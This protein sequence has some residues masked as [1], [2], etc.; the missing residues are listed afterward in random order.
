MLRL[1]KKV[2]TKKTK[3]NFM[4]CLI[5]LV[6]VAVIAGGV[7]ILGNLKGGSAGEGSQ[8]ATIRY[9]IELA[10]EEEEVL[11]RFVAAAE[12]QDSCYVGEKERAK[13]IIREVTY[14]EAKLQTT[15]KKTGEVFWADIPDKY[16]INVTLESEGTETD[17][18][19]MADSGTNLKVGIETSV[20]GKGY[21]GYGFITELEIVNE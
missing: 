11:N 20:K 7:Y 14:T 5:I 13:A 19:I 18:S 9:T 12:N 8:A 15:N 3:F 17:S 2:M 21:A 1:E 10:K 4:D 16:C 6:V